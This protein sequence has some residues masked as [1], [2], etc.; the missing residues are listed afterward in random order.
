MNPSGAGL[1]DATLVARSVEGDPA[2]FEVLL[3]RY[4]RPLF[5]LAVRL[6]GDRGDAEDALQDAF[7]S[8]WRRLPDFRGDAAFSSWLYRIVINRCLSAGRRRPPTVAVDPDQWK[9]EPTSTGPS[10]EQLAISA[11]RMAA[12]RDAVLMLPAE[13][14]TCWVLNQINGLTYIEIAE[15][16][17]ASPDSVRGR[18]Q[19]ARTRL[20]EVME[21]WR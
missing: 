12:L 17:H 5:T 16:L 13:Q 1:D 19:R 18:I 9:Q 10:P 15:I 6:L 2:A 11:S 4:Q 8:A 20:A 7:I 21:P 14:R 3:R